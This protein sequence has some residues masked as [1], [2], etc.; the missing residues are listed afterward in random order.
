MLGSVTDPSLVLPAIRDTFGL[1]EDGRE[2]SATIATYRTQRHVLL[3]LDNFEQ[4]IGAATDVGALVTSARRVTV[5]VT[6]RE[7]RRISGEHEY[8]VSQ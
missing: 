6:S 4:V 5:L 2:A 8:E 1:H 7:V 3:V